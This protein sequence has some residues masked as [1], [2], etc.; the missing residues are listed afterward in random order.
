M[1]W[2]WRREVSKMLAVETRQKWLVSF[3]TME[4][5]V[6]VFSKPVR[7]YGSMECLRHSAQAGETWGPQD[8]DDDDDGAGT[9]GSCE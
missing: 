8:V 3:N 6:V 2:L 1:K 4:G 5:G 9:S 7:A